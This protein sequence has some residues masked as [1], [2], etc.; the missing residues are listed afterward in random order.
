MQVSTRDI[1]GKTVTGVIARP[2][3]D[4]RREVIMM[5]HFDD[6]TCL[7]FVSPRGERALRELA[8]S[9]RADASGIEVPQL[10]LAV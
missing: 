8:S 9:P 2:A 7:E 5:L 10:A 1:T 6:G 4:G 3:R